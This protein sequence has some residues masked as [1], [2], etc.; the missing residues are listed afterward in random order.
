MFSSTYS[1]ETYAEVM[2]AFLSNF[3]EEKSIIAPF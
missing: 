1:G 3:L 2:L